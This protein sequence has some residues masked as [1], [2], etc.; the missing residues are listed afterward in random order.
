M[1]KPTPGASG[2]PAALCRAAALL[3]VL[4]VCA[5]ACSKED[6]PKGP[7][8]D[9]A[10]PVAAAEAV[11]RDA[12]MRIRAVGNVEPLATV[13]VKSQVGGMIVEQFV[14][15]GQDVKAGDKLFQIDPRPYQLAIE[16]SEAKIARDQALLDK[17]ERDLKR[18][19]ELRVKG[20]VDEAQYDETFA[21]AKTLEEIGR[22][23]CRERV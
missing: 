7:R 8:G 20:A 9:R 15:D 13:A 22:A 16:E 4:A 18:Y 2:R 6:K 3:L 10:A 21:Q 5:A 14:T 1:I 17:A 11:K 19:A 12:S 23:S